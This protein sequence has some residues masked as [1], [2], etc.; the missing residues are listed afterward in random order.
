[1]DQLPESAVC[2]AAVAAISAR[3]TPGNPEPR[4]PAEQARR[5]RSALQ[6]GCAREQAEG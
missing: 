5:D 2:Q 6:A 4:T 3:F 1:M